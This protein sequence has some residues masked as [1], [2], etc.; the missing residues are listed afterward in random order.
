[1]LG[2]RAA[3]GDLS[4]KLLSNR[5][6][7]E[8][9]VV[10][11]WVAVTDGERAVI[12]QVLER[13]TALVRRAAG[14]TAEAQVLA[15]NVDTFFVVTS[16]NR[17]F[18]ERRLE[19]YVAAVWSSGAEPAIVLNKIDLQEDLGPLLEAIERVALG[20][21]VMRV[22]AVSGDGLEELRAHISAG[23]TIG[24]IGS[25]GVGKSTLM[26]R[27]LGRE[28]SSDQ[29]TAQR[30]ARPSYNDGAAARRAARRRIDDRHA[31]DARARSAR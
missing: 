2:C 31:R 10:G 7:I 27:L 30:R 15:A 25:S 29:R 28:A 11:D 4:G 26:N 5:T 18:N 6:R 3:L 13:R 17:E 1:M 9:P 23:R 19:R 20:V 24:F 21:P 12:H 8:R 22:S 14:T 16:A